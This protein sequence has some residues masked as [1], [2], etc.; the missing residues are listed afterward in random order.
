MEPKWLKEKR[1]E[2]KK[3]FATLPLPT[4]EEYWRRAKL[5]RIHFDRFTPLSY[6]KNGGVLGEASALLPTKLLTAG[7]LLYGENT[8]PTSL[9]IELQK[10]GVVLTTLYQASQ[11]KEAIVS[12]YLGRGF[13]G[14]EDKFLTQ[15]EAFWQT[16]AFCYIP[17]GL[18]ME[19]PIL[20][21]HSFSGAGKSS[22]PRLLVVVEAGAEA[23]LLHYSTSQTEQDPNYL[24]GVMEFYVGEGAIL[25]VIDLQALSYQTYEI[26]QKRIELGRDAKLKWALD[27]QG[28]RISKTNIETIL[29]GEGSVA[30]V[31]GLM[32]GNQKQHLELYSKTQH[33]TPHTTADILVK[34]TADDQATTIFQGMIR[35]EPT[36][37]KT[38]SY[39]CNNN[40]IL[41]DTAH[42]DSIPR[43][44][45]EA[46][47]VKASHGATIGEVDA[48]QMFYLRS[49]GL[50]EEEA[51][52][53]LI[54]GFY[55]DIFGRIPSEPI[56]EVL[57]KNL[58]VKWEE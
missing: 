57:R 17:R 55:E 52:H 37:Q 51:Q 58:E 35:I 13:Q 45:I 25:N 24:N 10:K 38:E 6:S 1:E 53:L 28:G 41:S 3:R 9:S 33:V 11:E 56:R 43:L 14:Y 15:N 20:I 48:E 21:T 22:F 5:D 49:K 12:K 46:D 4:K 30:Q 31:L 39:M 2:A 29:N 36:A 42:A 19:A 40:L 44:E 16:G 18:T 50:T 7:E 54:N 32:C 47:D 23:T 26:A 27:I 8:S 34:A